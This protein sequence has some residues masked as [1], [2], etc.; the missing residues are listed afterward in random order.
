MFVTVINTN[1][2]GEED[3]ELKVEQRGAGV[4]IVRPRDSIIALDLD[5][6]SEY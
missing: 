4:G 3:E 5:G 6:V 1:M 2:I